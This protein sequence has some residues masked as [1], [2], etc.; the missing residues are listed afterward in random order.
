MKPHITP[1]LCLA[2][3]TASF[4]FQ[5][6]VVYPNQCKIHRELNVLSYGLKIHTDQHDARCMERD[7]P[8]HHATHLDIKDIHK[9]HT[10]IQK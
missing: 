4:T 7:A 2:T 8:G 9:L 1:F 3:T 6:F 10:N 5:L